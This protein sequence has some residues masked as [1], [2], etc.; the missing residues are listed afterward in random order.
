MKST[1]IAV[2]TLLAHYAHAAP[3]E[4]KRSASLEKYSKIIHDC[5]AP[6]LPSACWGVSEDAATPFPG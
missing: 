5:D 6:E 3:Y 2:S 4:G 1:V